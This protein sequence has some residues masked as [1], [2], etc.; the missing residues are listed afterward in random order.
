ML[1]LEG[2]GALGFRRPI[3]WQNRRGEGMGNRSSTE[4]YLSF[5][6]EQFR[7]RISQRNPSPLSPVSPISPFLSFSF[8]R[9][10]PLMENPYTSPQAD[11][12]RDPTPLPPDADRL[13]NLGQIALAWEKLR[14]WYN[15]VL[16]I[17]ALLA[18]VSVDA[19]LL[20]EPRAMESMI[21]AALAANACFC[22]GPLLEGYITWFVRPVPWLRRWI[23]GIGTLGAVGL[24]LGVV[25]AL[26][27]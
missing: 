17:V 6:A 14:L 5:I 22:V 10:I 1:E 20:V 19:S 15:A 21:L 24:T 11:P 27:G 26:V 9:R 4:L 3:G 18:V 23:F 13:V 16:A 12:R 8:S 25:L 2:D 7:K